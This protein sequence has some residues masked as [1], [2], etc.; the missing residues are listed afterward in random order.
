M[1]KQLGLPH[2]CPHA[3]RGMH[4]TFAIADGASADHVANVLGHG[5]AEITRRHYIA[6][7]AS[8]KRR[9][10]TSPASSRRRPPLQRPRA[11]PDAV[12][13]LLRSMSPAER[14]ASSPPSRTSRRPGLKARPCRASRLPS[15]VRSRAPR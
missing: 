1:C 9:P 5:S 2:V 8:A 11:Q 15:C 12:L 3:L 10:E 4:A 14:A 13:K 6:P 7:A